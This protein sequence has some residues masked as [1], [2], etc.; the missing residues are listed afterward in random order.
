MAGLECA[1]PGNFS[2]AHQRDDKEKI[3]K[4][5]FPVGY[6]IRGT[7]F[8]LKVYRIFILYLVGL[9]LKKILPAHARQVF[10]IFA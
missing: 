9:H 8:F 5:F 4:F 3:C 1:R 7:H 6:S 2:D 10:E